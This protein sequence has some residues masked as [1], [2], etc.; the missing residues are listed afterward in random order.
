MSEHLDT[1]NSSSGARHVSISFSELVR[2]IAF[3]D[4]NGN[5][6]PPPI[7]RSFNEADPALRFPELTKA[8][9][10]DKYYDFNDDASTTTVDVD[11][12][13]G[14]Q[15]LPNLL[16]GDSS[17][18]EESIYVNE[19]NDKMIR[20]VP[21][22]TSPTRPVY[23]ED[24]LESYQD[25][26]Q[27]ESDGWGSC[28]FASVW[29]ISFIGTCA[30][31]LGCLSR[32]C[33]SGQGA[34]VDSDDAVDVAA[35]ALNADKGAV[36]SSHNGDGGTTNVTYVCIDSFVRFET[37]LF[38]NRTHILRRL[39]QT[40]EELLKCIKWQLLR[41]NVQR[42]CALLELVPLRVQEQLHVEDHCVEN[43]APPT[44]PL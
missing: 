12:E 38:Y 5:A 18:S 19:K 13:E 22:V 17:F 1:S 43:Q 20:E 32:C 9:S 8:P 10:S 15:S 29:Y 44:P 11:L 35:F 21:A 7:I 24:D 16:Y 25:D 41:H 14:L 23:N 28:L 31:I 26:K 42:R 4:D 33:C 2:I 6:K 36:F 40:I 34:A 37:I 39:F 27:P 3:D 30:G